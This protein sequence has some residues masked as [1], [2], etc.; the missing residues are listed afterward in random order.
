MSVISRRRLLGL[1]AVG[2]AAVAGSGLADALALG[3]PGDIA[4]GVARL[5]FLMQPLAGTYHGISDLDGNAASDLSSQPPGPF[6]LE[7]NVYDSPPTAG[8][9]L[10]GTFSQRGYARAEAAD[11]GPGG[12]ASDTTGWYAIDAMPPDLPGGLADRPLRWNVSVTCRGVRADVSGLNP[13]APA[14]EMAV[15]GGWAVTQDPR[16]APLLIILGG[17]GELAVEEPGTPLV[18]GS[19]IILFAWCKSRIPCW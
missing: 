10:I 8:G 2:G 17:R 7:W 3:K 13:G 14:G 16:L 15:T 11:G 4:F 5:E 9:S 12:I 1:T 6:R 18:R 19:K